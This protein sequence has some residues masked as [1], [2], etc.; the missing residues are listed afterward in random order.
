MTG[1][2]L[3]CFH[4]RT[5]LQYD[6]ND[7]QNGESLGTLACAKGFRLWPMVS[8]VIVIWILLGTWLPTSNIH[9]DR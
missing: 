7:G 8:A 1:T 6:D 2:E 3:F 4:H 5:R 9:E